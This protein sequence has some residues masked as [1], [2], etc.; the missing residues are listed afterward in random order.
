MEGLLGWLESWRLRVGPPRPLRAGRSPRARVRGRGR[1]H[2]RRG[3]SQAAASSC[4]GH[5]L[6][7]AT[8]RARRSRVRD[9][10]WMEIGWILPNQRTMGRANLDR[11]DDWLF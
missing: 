7:H 8:D 10:P 6:A 1:A 4:P 2:R 3:K 5:I 9:E 11:I